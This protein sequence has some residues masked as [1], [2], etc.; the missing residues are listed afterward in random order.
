MRVLGACEESQAVAKAFRKLG[1]EAF[2]CDIRPCSGGHPEWHYQEDVFEVLSGSRWD[3]MIGH[4]PCTYLSNVSAP[5]LFPGRTVDEERYLKL[6]E[7]RS[8]FMRLWKT[9]KADR[10]CIE[11]PTPLKAAALPPFDQVIQPYMF[12]DPWSKRTCL[13]LRNLPPLMADLIIPEHKSWHASHS[14]SVMRSK[15]FPG[16]ARAMSEQWGVL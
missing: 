3:L 6:V 4:P 12:G 16:V 2:S 7:A 8:F 11:N 5:C 13:W 10:V 15:T 14:G 1:H 9:D